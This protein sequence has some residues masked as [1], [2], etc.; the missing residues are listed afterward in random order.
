MNYR[1]ASLIVDLAVAVVL[2]G[3]TIIILL[4]LGVIVL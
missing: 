2:L 4:A 1:T 3:G